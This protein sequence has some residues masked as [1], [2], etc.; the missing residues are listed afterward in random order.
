MSLLIA[1]LLLP[2]AL[3]IGLSACGVFPIIGNTPTPIPTETPSRAA[4]SSATPTPTATVTPTTTPEP[5]ETPTPVP[6][7]TRVPPP[8]PAPAAPPTAAAPA[9]APAAGGGGGGDAALGRRL[10]AQ[11]KCGQCHGTGNDSIKGP[12]IRGLR[13]S[14]ADFVS[15]VRNPVGE[16]E[17]Y[18]PRLLNDAELRAI[19]AF[20]I[21]G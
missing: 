19:F 6:T 4:T 7:A 3:V 15:Q 9:P 18:P 5:T 12:E 11:M 2:M 13:M 21:G 8:P 14:Y 1:R 20:L 10:F 16:M 17:A